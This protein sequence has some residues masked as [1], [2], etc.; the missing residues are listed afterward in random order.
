M[1]WKLFATLA[2]TAGTS[3]LDVAADSAE[4]TLREAVDALLVAEPELETQLLDSE[5]ELRSHIH[6]LCDGEDPFRAADGWET[7]VAA[8]DEI[9]LFPPV[10]GG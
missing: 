2:E 7:D 3:K 1:R 9:A 5:G 4:P 8:V 10:T 6:L